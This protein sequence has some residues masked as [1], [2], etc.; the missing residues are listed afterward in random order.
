MDAPNRL[1]VR[2]PG[3]GTREV[4]ARAAPRP[5]ISA[6]VLPSPVGLLRIDGFAA[7]DEEQEE[8]RAALSSFEGA[9][10]RG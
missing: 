2:D 7:T 6:E 4:E 9:G 8:L 1:T 5:R 3:G 10:A